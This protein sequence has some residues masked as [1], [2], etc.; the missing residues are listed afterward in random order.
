MG[1]SALR[2]NVCGVHQT[3]AAGRGGGRYPPETER[4]QRR[5]WLAQLLHEYPLETVHNGVPFWSA[6]KKPPTPLVFDASDPLHMVRTVARACVCCECGHFLAARRRS[7]W[8]Q[9]T[10]ARARSGYLSAQMRPRSGVLRAAQRGVRC[11]RVWRRAQAA[12]PVCRSVRVGAGRGAAHSR[13]RG[14]GGWA[15]DLPH[16]LVA[17]PRF[18]TQAKRF[19]EE[20]AA[21]AAAGDL[22]AECARL[23]GACDSHHDRACACDGSSCGAQRRCPDWT[24]SQA[25]SQWTRNTLRRVRHR[26]VSRARRGVLLPCNA[27]DDDTNGHV[28][29]VAAAGN[30]RARQYRCAER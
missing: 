25:A 3:G 1:A 14:R 20:A 4:A 9:R 19:A 11:T 2:G 22:D 13:E 29:F 12:A 10:S 7:S 8:P 6:S 24:R 26:G 5:V 16:V 23:A 17:C 18:G 21:A 27:S 28:A 30:L 15:H